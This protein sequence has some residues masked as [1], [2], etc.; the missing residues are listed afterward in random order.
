AQVATPAGTGAPLRGSDLRTVDVLEDAY[1]LCRDDEVA[2]VGRMRDLG[3]VGA[4]VEELDGRGLCAV[5]GLVDCHT[6][7]AWAGDRVHEFSLRAGG[8]SY[9]EW[10]AAG[11][12]IL[13]TV[14][15][16]RALGGDGLVARVEQHA[17]WMLE[18]RTTDWRGK[19][20]DG[21]AHAQ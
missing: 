6:H 2:A 10:H 11:G 1:I 4:D 21:V 9:E 5:P 7:P 13:S 16:T 3:S 14:G 15:A 17:A 18:H 12:G 19:L 20:G 8:S